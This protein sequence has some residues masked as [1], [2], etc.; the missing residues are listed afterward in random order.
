MHVFVSIC[1]FI[2]GQNLTR[3]LVDDDSGFRGGDVDRGGERR[4]DAVTRLSSWAFSW[5]VDTEVRRNASES[6][7]LGVRVG[8]SP[9]VPSPRPEERPGVSE[10]ARA[11]ECE[12]RVKITNQRQ[13]SLADFGKAGSG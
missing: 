3:R 1:V 6:T 7:I 4:E 12:P 10:R 13:A 8:N 9:R 2:R 11:G 5:S